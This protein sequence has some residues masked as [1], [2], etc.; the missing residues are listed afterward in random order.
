LSLAYG[1]FEGTRPRRCVAERLAVEGG[2]RF[3]NSIRWF[4]ETATRRSSENEGILSANLAESKI[5]PRLC[6]L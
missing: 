1:F 3:A 4:Y 2:N 6:L 5:E